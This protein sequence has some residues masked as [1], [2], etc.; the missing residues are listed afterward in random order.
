MIQSKLLTAFSGQMSEPSAKR[1]NTKHTINL[2]NTN[3]I[4]VDKAFNP[5]IAP[6]TI[7]NNLPRTALL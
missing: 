4:M 7:N 2:N 3:A 1:Y 5:K 6:L